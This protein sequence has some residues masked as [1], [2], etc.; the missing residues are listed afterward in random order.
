MLANAN[1]NG[2]LRA[3]KAAR[4]PK[5]TSPP[6]RFLALAPSLMLAFTA[7]NTPAPRAPAATT[8][9]PLTPDGAAA[10]QAGPLMSGASAQ[11]PAPLDVGAPPADAQRDPSGLAR[12]ILATGHGHEHPRP[13]DYAEL[14]YAGWQRNGQ[15]FEGTAT[16]GDSGRYDLAELVP[17]LQAELTKMV[18]GEK[19]RLWLPGALAFAKRPT[20]VNAPRGDMTYDVELVRIIRV[21]RAP[22]DV[23]AAP[24]GAK[25]TASGL[26]YVVLKKGAGKRHPE[27]SSR[28]QVIYSAWRADGHLFQ[29]SLITA[30]DVPVRLKLLPPGWREGML[31]MVEGEKRRL[32]LPGKLAFGE[33]P[34][35][36]EPLPFGPPAGPVVFDVELVK[37]LDEPTAQPPGHHKKKRPA[38]SR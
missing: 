16:N 1:S 31:G 11:S 23:R 34:P 17:G 22:D 8:T 14:R 38:P 10:R 36:Q 18:E 5:T 29:T 12:K 6:P 35:G 33:L 30:D 37:I 24:K 21:P 32:W 15:Q 26:A 4:P 13:T 27:E 7:C 25:T 19:R 9:A 3:M 20:F 28:T 2:K